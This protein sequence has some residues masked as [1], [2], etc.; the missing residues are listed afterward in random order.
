[1]FST[2]AQTGSQS[3][4]S[5][6]DQSF[7]LSQQVQESWDFIWDTIIVPEQQGSV[8]NELVNFSLAI[9]LFALIYTFIRYGSE[10]ARTKYIGTVIEMFLWP[11]AVVVLLGTYNSASGFLLSQL[12]GLLRGTAEDLIRQV[13]A[14][15]LADITLGT[16]TKQMQLNQLGTQ[17]IY[18]VVS[19]CKGISGEALQN[20]LE[21][22]EPE[23]FSIV[24]SISLI[25][26]DVNTDPLSAVA[27][28]IVNI[29][30]LSGN[31][32]GFENLVQG[33]DAGIDFFQG[34][35]T[36]VFQ[37]R[38]YPLAQSV[39]YIL[40]WIFLNLVETSLLLTAFLAPLAVALSLLPVSGKPI[41][42]WLVGFLSLYNLKLGYTIIVG[43]IASVI[44][45]TEGSA[46]EIVLGYAFVMF[47]SLFAPIIATLLA[48]GGGIAIYQGIARRAAS[49][50][51]AASGGATTL[52]TGGGLFK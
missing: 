9:A 39:L 24:D 50:T 22:K 1:M 16:A 36:Q 28:T 2:L 32:S 35:F 40:Q 45:N 7:N 34:G 51:S 42:A 5:V 20:C 12:I 21:A 44:V 41:F 37:D 43:I 17:R 10:I 29:R 3:A 8:W 19:E 26:G 27:Q 15:Q 18:Q 52:L 23:M 14:L 49:I 4:A 38:L 13:T 48:G 25:D 30:T 33:V 6:L 31:G 47:S 11:I 46:A